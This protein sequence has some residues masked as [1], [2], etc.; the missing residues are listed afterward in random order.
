MNTLNNWLK[1]TNQYISSDENQKPTHLLLNGYKLFIKEENND[2]FLKKYA[3][4]LINNEKLYV[5]E[6]KKETFKLFFDLDFLLTQEKYEELINN[7]I[8]I[9]ETD[10]IDETDNGN[11]KYLFKEDKEK[12]CGDGHGDED[13]DN[14]GCDN[15]ETEESEN[16]ENE[17]IQNE[18]IFEHF[19]KIIN[20]VIYDFYECYYDC[21]V[22]TANIKL[23]KKIC[24]NEENPENIAS[25]ELVKK[26]YHLHFPN[27]IIN[28]NLA[29]E[30]RKT[31]IFRLQK[32]KHYFENDIKDIV[33]EHVFTSSGLRLT[34]SR[35]GHF[36]SQT[37]E[38]IDEGRPYNLL[39]A[40]KNN[41][42]D[43]DLNNLYKENITELI[44]KTSI[45]TNDKNITNIKNNPNLE[46]DYCEEENNED[47]ND[48][49]MGTWKRLHKDDIKHIEI[50]RFFNIYIKDYNTK[51]IKRVFYSENESVYILCS[52]S[53]YCTNIG[54][55]HNSEH[56]Y[57]KLNK[58]GICQKC[59]CK[60]DTLNGRKHG[61]CKDYSSTIIPCTPQLR[62]ILNFKEI[63]I[64]KTKIIKNNKLDNELQNINALLEN[65]MN[66]WYNQFT[67]KEQLATK[68]KYNRKK[69]EKTEKM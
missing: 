39:F 63:K 58:E 56:I 19:I 34:G 26:G 17:N 5:V 13:G 48:Y 69:S 10:K 59:F 2:I 44:L 43:N 8:K 15:E 33:D 6:C 61:Y 7:K 54:K 18:N 38:F 68:K 21:I 25:K 20:D 47:H 65:T 62:K 22:T 50:L 23:V 32:Y 57:F 29:L 30:I 49:T 45:I 27:I 46:C 31:C 42:M 40:L 14:D 51:D 28:K 3:E 53:K 11:S 67:N 55:N 35:K 52:Q 24:K 60:C 4:A 41:E 1:V 66:D 12:D 9:L 37:K 36:V 16:T 64:D